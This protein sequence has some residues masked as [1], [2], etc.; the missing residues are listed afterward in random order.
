MPSVEQYRRGLLTRLQAAHV[1]L[2]QNGQVTRPPLDARRD[3]GDWTRRL[4]PVPAPSTVTAVVERY[5][6]L[7]TRAGIS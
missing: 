4:V 7:R 1:L 2:F 6:R 3:A 5:L